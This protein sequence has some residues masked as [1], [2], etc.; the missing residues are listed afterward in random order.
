M[1]LLLLYNLC[2]HI[3]SSFLQVLHQL[4]QPWA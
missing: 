1:E 3:F 4:D 2:Q